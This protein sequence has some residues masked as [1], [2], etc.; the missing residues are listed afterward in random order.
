MHNLEHILSGVEIVQ[1]IG[2]KALD[3]P[4]VGFDSRNVVSGQL[5]IAISGTQVDG[6]KYIPDA[7]A[8]GAKIIVCEKQPEVQPEGV[9]FVLVADSLVACGRIAANFYG[10]PSKNLKLVGITGTNGKT[11]TVTLLYRMFRELGYK[12]GL[13]STVVNY[14]DDK[15]VDATHTTPDAVELNGLLNQMVDAGCEYCFMEVSSHSISQHRIEGLHFEGGIFSNITHDHLDYH[16]TFDAYIKAK[17]AFFDN[18]P[19]ASFAL[20]NVDDKNGMVMV[21]NCNANIKTYGL[22][23]PADYKS[24]IIES[25]FD[26][27]QLNINGNDVWTRFLGE[28]NGYNLTAVYAT[29]ILLGADKDEVLRILSLLGPVSGRFEYV[30]SKTGVTAIVDYAH[31]PDALDNVIATINKM[32]KEDQRL[33]VV[34]GAGGNRDKTKRPIMA[35]V[36][37]NNADFVVLTSDN[38]RN[39]DPNDILNDMRQGIKPDQMGKVLTIVDRKEGIKTASL[40]AKP[41]DII[42]VAGKGHEDYQEIKGVK[43]HFDDKEVLREVFESLQ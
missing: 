18:L 7:I 27:M 24:K 40:L 13:L 35:S 34:I 28:F 21:Q 5:F 1:V 3:V 42:L 38:P 22:K 17:K 19:K 39:E 32:R 4:C 37:V 41:N 33:F 43:H 29:S 15:R 12:V 6:H 11:T 20:T 16:K 8:K 2:S 23:S 9:T 14:I 25:H 36:A 30:K 26:G 10:N 31:T